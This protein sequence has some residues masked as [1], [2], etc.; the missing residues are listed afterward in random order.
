MIAARSMGSS[1]SPLSLL[2]PPLSLA[3][4]PVFQ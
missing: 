4:D 3:S 2:I 1:P